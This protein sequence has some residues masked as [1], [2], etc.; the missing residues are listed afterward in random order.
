[1][2]GQALG[3]GVLL[4]VGALLWAFYFLPIWT[5]RRQ[6]TTA[7]K[8]AL[9]IQRTL[10]MLAETTEVPE[11]VRVEA[12][13]RQA[14][15]HER[16]LE[17]AGR[18]QIAEHEAKLAEAK[19]AER[20]A[21]LDAKATKRRANALKRELIRRSQA[22]RV[23]RLITAVIALVGVIGLGVGI[24]FAIIGFGSTVLGVSAA[25]TLLT[26]LGLVAM[27][28]RKQAAE[29]PAVVAQ[30][31]VV[32]Q[33]VTR[34]VAARGHVNATRVNDAHT[35]ASALQTRMV[36]RAQQ[37]AASAADIAQAQ[38]LLELARQQAEQA[39]RDELRSRQAQEQAQLRAGQGVVVVN[40][41]APARAERVVQRAPQRPNAPSATVRGVDLASL[42]TMGV[43]GDTSEG[44]PDLDAVLMRRRNAS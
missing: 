27:A 39:Q 43:I 41:E 19:L 3:G 44:M 2:N 9:R 26:V 13:A 12:T 11:E 25:V 16:M 8:N 15:A 31:T 37:T 42:K 36:A 24:V 1:M 4:A 18:S 20:K 29:K 33:Q 34:T 35:R 14:L 21:I 10:R 40:A 28:P 6:F 5:K 32:T 23:T 38:R 17:A 22:V 7:Q 30:P